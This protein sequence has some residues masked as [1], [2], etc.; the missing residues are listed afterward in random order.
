MKIDGY[1]PNLMVHGSALE[2][3]NFDINPQ[4]MFS[5]LG[6]AYNIS[7]QRRNSQLHI[8]QDEADAH[9]HNLL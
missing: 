6:Y 9:K 8:L 4:A 7:K 2:I 3:K 5:C 1:H